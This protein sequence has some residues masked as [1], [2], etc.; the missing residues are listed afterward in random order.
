MLFDFFNHRNAQYLAIF[1]LSLVSISVSAEALSE[2]EINQL[3]DQLHKA[4]ETYVLLE[5]HVQCYA[6]QD[7]VFQ[8]R[9]KLLQAKAG[10]LHKEK[11]AL[12]IKLE[13]SQQ[14]KESFLQEVDKAQNDVHDLTPKILHMNARIQAA[15]HALE[16]C[17]GKK[18]IPNFLCDWAGEISGLK[19][20]M[21]HLYAEKETLGIRLD[22]ARAHLEESSMRYKQAEEKFK[23][24]EVKSE[25]NKNDILKTETDIKLIKKSLMELRT[26][27]QEYFIELNNFE[28][29]FNE[30]KALD[31]NS[32]RRFVIHRLRRESEKL[33]EQL[34]QAS[35]LSGMNGLLLP[36]GE[37]ICIN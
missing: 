1:T 2:A 25:E 13:T 37:R 21:R 24:T 23:A 14:E 35:S 22:I 7:S 15:E 12:S 8:Q 33:S 36:S 34:I 30:F 9:S 26:A 31:P 20:E 28:K 11:Q 3:N 27:R 6:E 18:W 5:N 17:K 10:D 29:T 19:K 16:E 4:S 32:E